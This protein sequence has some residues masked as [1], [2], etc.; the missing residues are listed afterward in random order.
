MY[1]TYGKGNLQRLSA[2][3]DKPEGA[4][5]LS[6]RDVLEYQL[7]RVS[8]WQ[9]QSEIWPLTHGASICASA[10]VISCALTNSY[11]RR[12][13][14][15]M[16]FGRAS[17]YAMAVGMPCVLGMI[18]HTTF[19]TGNCLVGDFG[20]PTCLMTKSGIIQLLVG[21]LYPAVLCPIFG[22]IQA[23][24]YLTKAIEPSK[25]F[26]DS[27][28]I[29]AK[30]AVPF[31]RFLGLSLLVNMFIGMYMSKLEMDTFLNVMMKEKPQETELL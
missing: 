1:K 7:K 22:L 31:K 4:I 5:P 3:E 25:K 15:L 10:T 6:R 13:F 14:N 26:K 2:Y 29:V 27:I 12:Y 18:T 20:C 24:K 21:G 30:T 23:R 19:V 28:Q 9:P 17:G 11:F 8:E 16:H